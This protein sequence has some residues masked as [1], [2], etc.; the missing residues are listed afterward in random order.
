MSPISRKFFT[1]PFEVS[2][3][4]KSQPLVAGLAAQ[5]AGLAAPFGA[6]A[7]QQPLH[8]E[9]ASRFLVCRRR[10]QPLVAGLVAGL[11]A[12]QPFNLEAAPR[13]LLCNSVSLRSARKNY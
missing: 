4:S 13:F 8:R 9:V 7:P 11:A 2:A 6:P 12:Q 10:S 1:D 5:L 3:R